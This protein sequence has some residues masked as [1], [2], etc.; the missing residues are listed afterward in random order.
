MVN[1][2]GMHANSQYQ[3]ILAA[4]GLQSA[5]PTTRDGYLVQQVLDASY[6]SAREETWVDLP[7]EKGE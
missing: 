1:A 6:R 2:M 4:T 3:M 5:S 7:S